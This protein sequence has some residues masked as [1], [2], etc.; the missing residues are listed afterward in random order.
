[1]ATVVQSWKESLSIF[2]P[3]NLK[4]FALVTLKRAWD[5]SIP[6]LKFAWWQIVGVIWLWY[7]FGD[8]YG[9][10]PWHQWYIPSLIVSNVLALLV[11]MTAL[12]TL[13][14][15][16]ELKDMHYYWRYAKELRFKMWGWI[17]SYLLLAV[18]VFVVLLSLS[19]FSTRS[20]FLIMDLVGEGTGVEFS[21]GEGWLFFPSPNDLMKRGPFL[22]HYF[23]LSV[24]QGVMILFILDAKNSF[25]SINRSVSNG[26]RFIWY[27]APFLVVMTAFR[28]AIYRLLFFDAYF[29]V[30]LQTYLDG[31]YLYG[32]YSV[33]LL[34]HVSF[35]F[36]GYAA[37]TNFY[38]KRVYEQG[39][40]YF[41]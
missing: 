29:D 27:N 13:R 10:Y 22:E 23:P 25:I 1:M 12:I 4:L 32:F 6:F 39:E 2:I 11:R 3:K 34:L 17:V 14:P 9:G 30:P 19:P 38:T 20:L 15:S 24:V 5:S 37:I 31:M 28:V 16:I 7:V 26:L 41:Q 40:L 8:Y 33:R 18:V 36:I 35:S 21:G